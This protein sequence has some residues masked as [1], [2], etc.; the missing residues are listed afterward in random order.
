MLK[1][2]P[3]PRWRFTRGSRKNIG[4]QWEDQGRFATTFPFSMM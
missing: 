2:R 3:N 1:I 4:K